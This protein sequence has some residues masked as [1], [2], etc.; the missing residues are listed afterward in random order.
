MITI[1]TAPGPGVWKGQKTVRK[2]FPS[3]E[4]IT[5]IDNEE[6]ERVQRVEYIVRDVQ[7]E[8]GLS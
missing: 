8:M 3:E 2:P 4:Y 1:L 7:R 5:I 6:R